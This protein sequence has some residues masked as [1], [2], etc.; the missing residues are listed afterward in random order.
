MKDGLCPMCK[1]TDVYMT[2][3]IQN[4]AAGG[5]GLRF[6]AEA[7]REKNFFRSSKKGNFLLKNTLF[8]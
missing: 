8:T 6:R 4:L 5:D 2:E 1:S 7:G 3:D